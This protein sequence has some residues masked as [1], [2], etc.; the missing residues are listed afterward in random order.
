MN[1]KAFTLVELVVV[2]T[3]LAILGTFGFISYTDYTSEARDS[4]RLADMWNI[5]KAI[6]LNEIN[7]WKLPEVTN[8]V[9]I[10]VWT[11]TIFSQWT[12]W[13][14]T[15]ADLKW[16]ISQNPKDPLTKLDYSYS[17]TFD[18]S[19]YE[20]GW[21]IENDKISYNPISQANAWESLAPALLRWNYNWQFVK[22]FS[23]E[24]VTLYATP[25]ITVSD[26]SIVQLADL[27]DQ[28]KF[29]YD[30]FYNL[31]ANFASSKYNTN[32]WNTTKYLNK[33][34]I[35]LYTWPL[36]GLN[37]ETNQLSLLS[38]LKSAYNATDIQNEYIIK[39]IM[40]LDSNNQVE[41]IKTIKN[42][43][44]LLVSDKIQRN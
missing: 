4:A 23:W 39:K 12:F 43:L 22:I 40:E 16:L 26:T 17:L 25:S 9:E 15:I 20:L 37:N 24:D 5:K 27:G 6:D 10:K 33:D 7:T 41:S 30:W 14:T 28:N 2:I 44:N 11:Q 8:P 38:N 35:V 31:P 1:K 13:S 42:M 3:I 29:V 21:Y 19:E 36:L 18:G 32:W 34:N